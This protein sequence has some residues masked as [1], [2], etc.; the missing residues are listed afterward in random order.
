MGGEARGRRPGPLLPRAGGRAVRRWGLLSAMRFFPHPM[1]LLPVPCCQ[2]SSPEAPRR[3]RPA[4]SRPP[5]PARARHR[6]AAS[7]LHLRAPPRAAPPRARPA[8]ASV[9]A[10]PAA[11]AARLGP[12]PGA[13]LTSP[14]TSACTLLLDS[15]A[16]AARVTAPRGGPRARP[17]G[18]R[19]CD[20]A[21]AGGRAAAA[22]GP[23]R[24][25]RVRSRLSFRAAPTVGHAHARE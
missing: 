13:S 1:P 21:A 10:H 20:P 22:G 9:R 8:G 24:R 2:T 17:A 18:A 19:G 4:F 23:R 12:A 14:W 25:R 16:Q 15:A 3:G 7:A 11:P 6:R 5:S